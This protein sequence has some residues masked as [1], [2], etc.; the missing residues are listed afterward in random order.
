MV[1]HLT[2]VGSSRD[3]IAQVLDEY[4]EA[5]I[6][7]ILALRG[8]PPKGSDEKTG[9]FAWAAELVAFVK[10]GLARNEHRGGGIPRRSSGY[11]QSPCGKWIT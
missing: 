4:Q 9:D 2:C 8:D 3:D 1:S 10:K 6:S 7:N 11:T 5:G